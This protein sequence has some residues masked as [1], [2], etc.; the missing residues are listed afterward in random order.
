LLYNVHI[1]RAELDLISA[2]RQDEIAVL[3]PA[4]PDNM[5]AEVPLGDLH[6]EGPD[7]PRRAD[8]HYLRLRCGVIARTEITLGGLHGVVSQRKRWRRSRV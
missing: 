7:P 2:E 8:D 1:F 3:R 4:H 6:R 5:R